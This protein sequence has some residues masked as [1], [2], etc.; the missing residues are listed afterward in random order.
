MICMF[1]AELLKLSRRRVTLATVAGTLAFAVL[2]ATAVFL[3]A[4]GPGEPSAPR[5]T[6][7]ESLAQAG[8]ATEAF[9]IGASFAGIL[10]LVLF[11][12]NVAGE[13]S[14]GTFRTLLMRE[15]RRIALLA[16][17]MAALLAFVA[18]VLAFAE[19]LTV[20]ASTAIAPT[21][22]VSTASWFGVDGLGAAAADYG[23]ALA[24]LTAWALLG[25]ALAI[26]VRSI[27]I[28]LAIGIVWSGPFEHLLHDAWIGAGEW[29]PGL[30]LET[31]ISG[32]G[33]GASVT[34][35]LVLVAVYVCVAAGAAGIVFARRDVTV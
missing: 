29:F 1:E 3:S 30:L 33:N 22:D 34:R 31:L 16:G 19:I 6:S 11:I 18:G 27:P 24:G 2:A 12:A 21:Q 32:G 7:V 20:A 25:M 9:A 17:K 10:V 28:A 5:G 15:P 26:F 14:Q 13:I 4:T 8:G 35:A 23:S